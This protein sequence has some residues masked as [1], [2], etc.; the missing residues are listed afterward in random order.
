MPQSAQ[1]YLTGNDQIAFPFKE[2][3]LAL[4][5]VGTA[6]IHGPTATLPRNFLI[7]A[8][9]LLPS[10]FFFPT[11]VENGELRLYSIEHTGTDFR[12]TIVSAIRSTIAMF[13]I[14]IAGLPSARGAVAFQD[15]M[16]R[17]TLRLIVG[18][19]F[20]GYLGSMPP[21]ST[22]LFEDRLPFET[23]A[24]EYRP[25]RVEKIIIENIVPEEVAGEIAL[26]AG[27]NIQFTVNPAEVVAA[28]G[29]TDVKISARAGSGAGRRP[30]QP[31][32]PIDYI[33]T[34]NG[35]GPDEDGNL[36]I[37]PTQCH[38]LG[39][40]PTDHK[41]TIINDCS[42]CCSCEDY[43][44]AVEAL[45]GFFADLKVVKDQLDDTIVDYNDQV[46][47]YNTVIFPTIKTLIVTGNGQVG[48]KPIDPANSTHAPDSRNWATVVFRAN[49]RGHDLEGVILAI[50][51]PGF[52]AKHVVLTYQGVTTTIYQ[53]TD[54]GV[55]VPGISVGDM[56]K[57]SEAHVFMLVCRPHP[58]DA[59]GSAVI[60]PSWTPTFV[61]DPGT[62]DPAVI[63]W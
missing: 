55:A 57:G 31:P 52:T 20:A 12:F 49:N 22:D 19:E 7:D 11:L 37:D 6:P 25:A 39:L 8:I 28:D 61:G 40:F 27:Y 5:P 24:V 48:F 35:V 3:A 50:S 59:H 1:E 32:P 51:M 54:A 44:N 45:E 42:P 30:C 4:A 29:V 33:A 18:E 26:L 47:L 56:E 53:G 63:T 58:T 38:R 17:V 60:T 23:A 43:A 10:Q 62:S 13:D 46:T 14:P 16:F 9:I 15:T 2:D 36:T 34:I 41:I 21:L